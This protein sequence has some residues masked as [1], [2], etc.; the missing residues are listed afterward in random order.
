[1][2]SDTDSDSDSDSDSDRQTDT[3]IHTM[4]KTQTI[5]R[6]TWYQNPKLNTGIRNSGASTPLSVLG[7]TTRAI[8]SVLRPQYCQ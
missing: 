6:T 2:D 8:A 3:H 5:S 4:L 7:D 1:M